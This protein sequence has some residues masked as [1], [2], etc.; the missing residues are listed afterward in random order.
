[1]SYPFQWLEGS[2]LRKTGVAVSFIVIALHLFLLYGHFVPPLRPWVHL[3]VIG[4]VFP[5]NAFLVLLFAAF[6]GL[7]F[8]FW[9]GLTALLYALV[10]LAAFFPGLPGREDTPQAVR[11][12]FARVGS[13]TTVGA[14]IYALNAVGAQARRRL[15]QA[16]EALQVAQEERMRQERLAAIGQAVTAIVH[17]LR[18][19]LTVIIGFTELLQGRV[20]DP[21]AQRALE[22]MRE[23]A[24]NASRLIS[25]MRLFAGHMPLQLEPV[26]LRAVIEKVAKENPWGLRLQVE[27][28]D[29][30]PTIQADR[31]Q[32]MRVLTNLL[33]NARDALE[34]VPHGQVRIAARAMEGKVVLTVA[35]NGPGIPPDLQQRVFEP[36]FTTK[37]A[38]KGTGLGLSICQS[39]VQRHGGSISLWSAPGKGAIFTI[40]L[41]CQGP[42]EA[43]G[44]LAVAGGRGA[45]Y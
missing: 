9:G 22:Q 20:T 24:L 14:A 16:M 7:L 42:V 27:I 18:N 41:P 28:P 23:S 6:A 3:F 37:P 13:V 38:G 33:D 1:M 35:D 19:F 40:I 21:T 31:V 2:R 36:F 26:D 43:Q 17:D 5:T 30:L 10:V 25:D 39:I 12:Y 15:R 11:E 29:G 4:E 8:G 44:A 32:L 34:S 45:S